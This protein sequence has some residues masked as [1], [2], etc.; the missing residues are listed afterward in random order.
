MAL[1]A[2]ILRSGKG[3]IDSIKYAAALLY[4]LLELSSIIIIKISMML[5]KT[6]PEKNNNQKLQLP[7]RTASLVRPLLATTQ[8][9]LTAHRRRGK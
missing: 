7:K 8:A 4:K 1:S 5:G 3:V 6:T 2:T 9:H